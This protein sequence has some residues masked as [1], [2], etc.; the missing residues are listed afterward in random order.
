MR[1]T[2]TTT[3]PKILAKIVELVDQLPPTKDFTLAVDFA[4]D[5]Y[6]MF[7]EEISKRSI[8]KTYWELFGDVRHLYTFFQIGSLME[9]LDFYNRIRNFLKHFVFSELFQEL[10][11]LDP[12]EA[13]EIFLKLFQPPQQKE[14]NTSQPQS[15][16]QDQEEQ[17]DQ[18]DEKDKKDQPKTHQSPSGKSQ[19]QKGLSAD[20]RSLPVDMSEFRKQT[21]KI[22]KALGGGLLD[23][24]DFKEIAGKQA[25]IES[26]QITIG[27]IVE[28][29]KKIADK[30]TQKDLDI[31]YIARQKEII[32]KYRRDEVLES[33]IFPDNEM[34]I[35]DMENHQEVLKTLP[36]QFALD[37][38]V[39]LE[40]LAKK[41]LQVRDYQSRKLKKQA[42]YLLVDVSYSMSGMPSTYASGVALSLVRQAIDEGSIYFLRFFDN[43]TKDLHRISNKEEAIKMASVLVKNP[44]SGGGTNI[45][46]AIITAVKD[47][48]ND[49]ISFEKAEILI[50]TDGRDVV[51]LT[52]NSLNGI[53]LHSTLINGHNSGLKKVSDTYLELKT[54]DL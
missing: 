31:F 41:E 26:K 20:E 34:S 46:R 37:D 9:N 5:I 27:N 14:Q 33:V 40:K 29:I 10:D 53:K 32:D 17:R 38:E 19:D 39:F 44:S 1:V 36:S 22:E 6:A 45:E 24:D 23:R 7:A 42:L 4:C 8:F 48:K 11:K 15:Q 50:I 16:S 49:P 13:T 47:I 3:K 25:G 30:L 35:K 2:K 18:E 12:M 21:P 52:K 43:H 28:V 51:G 54:S